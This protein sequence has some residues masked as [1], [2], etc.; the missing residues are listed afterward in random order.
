MPKTK[1]ELKETM[2][3]KIAKGF[4]RA[5]TATKKKIKQAK[6]QDSAGKNRLPPDMTGGGA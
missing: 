1:K 4:K 3:G 2:A 6:V 5:A